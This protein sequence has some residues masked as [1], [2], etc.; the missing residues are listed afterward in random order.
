MNWIANLLIVI[1]VFVS[2]C[3]TTRDLPPPLSEFETEPLAVSGDPLEIARVAA[4]IADYG[5]PL[6]MQVAAL[7]LARKATKNDPGNR[8]C[9]MALS[10]CDM[11]V[12]SLIQDG[13]L[14]HRLAQEGYE[15]IINT[16]G[17]QDDPVAAYYLAVHLGLILRHQGIKAIVRLPELEQILKAACQKPE[18]DQGGPL[19]VLGMLYLKAPAWPNG[20]GDLDLALEYLER[21]AKEYPLHPANQIFFAEAL[22][23]D[24]RDSNA[25]EALRRSTALLN[26]K[27]WGDFEPFWRRDIKAL[28]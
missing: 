12:S 23:E 2:G 27:D 28:Q 4:G 14:I 6:S 16:G 19:R 3:A 21:A 11:F 5:S 26:S 9:S 8:E 20:I 13:E 22:K 25:K 7:K 24:G 15:A 17:I 1:F 18:T 10:K